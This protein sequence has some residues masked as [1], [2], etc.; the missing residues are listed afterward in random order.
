MPRRANSLSPDRLRQFA[1][2][3]AEAAIQELRAQISAIE[4]AF[5]DLARPGARRTSNNIAP[6]RRRRRRGMSAAQRKSVSL[7]MKKYW[8]AR[9][10]AKG[11]QK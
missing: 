5:P 2:A 10:K 4:Q 3:G 11:N 6:V 1:R 8:A 9:R 7:R